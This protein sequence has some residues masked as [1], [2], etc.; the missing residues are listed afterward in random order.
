[1]TRDEQARQRLVEIALEVANRRLNH[2]LPNG[3]A[4]PLSI[5]DEV[6][7]LAGFKNP[8][9]GHWCA[10]GLTAAMEQAGLLVPEPGMPARRGAVALLEF[11]TVHG[12]L[13]ACPDADG[14]P[15]F[16]VDAQ[17]G[18]IIAWKQNREPE[19]WL[20]T[21]ECH[22]FATTTSDRSMCGKALR[23]AAVPAALSQRCSSCVWE[24][25]KGHVAVIVATDAES[26]TTVGWNEGLS[27]G[28]VMMRRL[29]RD[30]ERK[31]QNCTGDGAQP[32]MLHHGPPA[33]RCTVCYGT[34][35]IRPIETVLWRR[36]GGFSGVARPV[37]A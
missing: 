37:A 17:P 11:V 14:I 24:T 10:A 23:A 13:A 9:K 7:K 28:R 4:H 25:R 22:A 27:P 31:C 18:D 34:G 2:L 36:P 35:R 19:E 29:W 1:M 6:R 30:P 15:M 33:P 21:R 16:F 20:L 32:S 12:R 8:R 3:G 26:I 5:P